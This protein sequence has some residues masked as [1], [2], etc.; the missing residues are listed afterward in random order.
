MSQASDL[1]AKLLP[2]YLAT[3]KIAA[4]FKRG[5]HLGIPGLG[6]PLVHPPSSGVSGLDAHPEPSRKRLTALPHLPVQSIGGTLARG[7][8]SSL[9]PSSQPPFSSHT[10]LFP[11]LHFLNP[12][13]PMSSICVVPQPPQE[14]LTMALL[15]SGDKSYLS[16]ESEAICF[17]EAQ[18]WRSM[19]TSR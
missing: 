4:Y 9:P 10:D 19:C 18:S 14:S 2:S 13:A 8:L 6:L 3:E 7:G 17:E 12:W 11:F 1:Q 15:G 5:C 16:W